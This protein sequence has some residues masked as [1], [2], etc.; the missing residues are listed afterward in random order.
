FQEAEVAVALM[1]CQAEVKPLRHVAR[2]EPPPLTQPE[3]H[4]VGLDCL[5]LG[6]RKNDLPS[7][8][9]WNLD[10]LLLYEVRVLQRLQDT[11][12]FIITKADYL[13][14]RAIVEPDGPCERKQRLDLEEF[15]APTFKAIRK[16]LLPVD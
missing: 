14:I 13:G 9:P 12:T 2:W 1:V 5:R 7:R 10:T 4:H 11:M 15:G 16:P 3:L 6:E 8:N